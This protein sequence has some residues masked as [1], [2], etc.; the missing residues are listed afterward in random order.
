MS[1]EQAL[2]VRQETAGGLVPVGL[3]FD[4]GYIKP[5]YIELIQRTSKRPDV[6]PG[7]LYDVLRQ[8][9]LDAVQVVP[10]ALRPG[11]VLFPDDGQLGAEPL[12]RSNDGIRPSP[13]AQFP[14]AEACADCPKSSWAN[15]NRKTK[16][17]KPPCKEKWQMLFIVRDWGLPRKISI[18]GMSL[19]PFKNLREQ[20]KQDAV[21]A[22]MNGQTRNLFDYTFKLSTQF[23]DGNKGAY[24]TLKFTDV[25]LIAEEDREQFGKLYQLYV[26][27]QQARAAQ[28]AEEESTEP[29]GEVVDAEV[30][31]V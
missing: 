10:L 20:L 6:K 8:M 21:I 11:R 29:V 13:F 24:F 25:K 2:A 31:E 7:K 23:V 4:D 17:G 14:Q 5:T 19:T 15:Y 22:R 30:V 9:E 18:G 1:Q 12:C 28:A 27:S 3:G 16:Q 26:M